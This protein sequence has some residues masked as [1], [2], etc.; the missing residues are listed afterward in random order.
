MRDGTP[1][2]LAAVGRIRVMVERGLIGLTQLIAWADAWVMKLEDSP[3]WLLELCTAPDVDTALG[4]LFDIP[5]FPF[6][7]TPE[8]RRAQDADHLASLFLRYRRG[9][10][11]WGDFLFIGGQFLDGA[12]GPWPCETF[13][14]QRDLLERTGYPEDLVQSQREDI[15]RDLREALERMGAAHRRFEA[16]A[17]GG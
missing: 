16:E 11:S 15:E 3:L 10:L 1:F 8:E 9:E 6:P 7:A 2:D 14:M 13:F 12:N 4:L 17:R 5:M